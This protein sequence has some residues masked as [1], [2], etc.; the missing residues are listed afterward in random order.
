MSHFVVID[1]ASYLVDPDIL[2]KIVEQKSRRTRYRKYPIK[3]AR[4]ADRIDSLLVYLL[5][6][7][8]RKIEAHEAVSRHR[9]VDDLVKRLEQ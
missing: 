9:M 7:D 3:T 2:T 5:G 4:L 1:P 8:E 6:H